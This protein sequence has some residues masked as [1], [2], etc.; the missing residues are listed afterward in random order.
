MIKY[1]KNQWKNNKYGVITFLILITIFV[2]FPLTVNV[3]IPE[4]E[5]ITKSM[6]YK[7]ICSEHI[8]YNSRK[9]VYQIKVYK[10]VSTGS[11]TQ[12]YIYDSFIQFPTRKE[13]IEK[14]VSKIKND[15]YL[16]NEKIIT[17]KNY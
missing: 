4:V 17:G 7:N 12:D 11:F 2:I 15:S 13:T 5:K 9:S 10:S 1:I 3:I 8:E 14:C 6:K 16:D